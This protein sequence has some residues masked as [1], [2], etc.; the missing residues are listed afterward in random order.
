MSLGDHLE[1]GFLDRLI[2]ASEFSL[3][4]NETK[5]I[6]DQAELIIFVCYVDSNKY[7]LKEEFLGLI[8]IVGSKGAEE[9]CEKVCEVLKEKGAD[10]S[11]IRFKNCRNH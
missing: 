4:A 1:N 7:S 3:M 11:L 6:A 8:E 10:V 9:L 5:D 2:V